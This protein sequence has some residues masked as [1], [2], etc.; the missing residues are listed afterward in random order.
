MALDH[1][2]MDRSMEQVLRIGN[3]VSFIAFANLIRDGIFKK[4]TERKENEEHKQKCIHLHM[5]C[6]QNSHAMMPL[7]EINGCS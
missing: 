7:I 3:Y 4:E 5:V 1:H 2:D 6:N